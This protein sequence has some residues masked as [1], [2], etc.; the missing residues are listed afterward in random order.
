V[1]GKKDNGRKGEG[2]RRGKREEE[3]EGRRKLHHGF[4]GEMDAPV[5]N[6]TVGRGITTGGYR[7]ISPKISPSKLFME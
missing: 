5:G 7:D 6:Q 4:F 3:T 1:E 2:R